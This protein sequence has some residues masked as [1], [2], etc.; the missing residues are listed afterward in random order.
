MSVCVVYARVSTKEQQDEGYSI[1]AQL[2]AIRA[3]CASEGLTIA[4]EFVEAESAGRAGRTQFGRMLSYLEE[5]RE[6]RVVVAHKLDRLYR[7]FRDQLSLEEDLGIRPRYVLGDLPDTPQGQFV[8]DVTLSQSRYFLANLSEEVSKGMREKASQGGWPWRAP[9]GYL[10]DTTTRTLAV[11]AQMA[12]LVRHAFERYASGTVSLASLAD[13]LYGMGMRMRTGSGINVSALHKM[14]KNPVYYGWVRYKDDIYRGAHDPLIS[15]EL[16]ASTQ[17]A[18]APNR[19]RNNGQRHTFVLRDYLYCAECGCKITAGYQKDHVYYRCTHGRGSCEQRRYTREELLMEQVDAVL[20]R[21]AISPGVVDAL[22]EEARLADARLAQ[23]S[24]GDRATAAAALDQAKQR[25]T[26]LLDA[27]LDGM[28]DKATYQARAARLAEERGTLELR[29]M[30]AETQLSDATAQVETLARTG[31]GARLAFL[32]G[33]SEQQRDVLSTVLWNLK[34]EDGRI[35]SYQWKD[36]F[37]FLEMEPSGAFCHPWWA[38]K[39]LNLRP[40]PCEGSALPL[41]Q[42]PVRPPER[43]RLF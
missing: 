1:P 40:L 22:V 2:K 42:S 24:A 26:A 11:D 20:S 15:D 17:E 19:R 29:Q 36:P 25:Q 35:A 23:R 5:H 30:V 12:P 16:F 41:S 38:M 43:R 37:G 21:I 13:E 14:L 9:V 32:N 39:D 4:A 18:F 8:R 10:N 27:Y 34:V 6:V 31:A 3:F 28:V 33:D 7:N